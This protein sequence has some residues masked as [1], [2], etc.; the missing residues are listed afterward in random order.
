L[1]IDW[2]QVPNGGYTLDGTGNAI[3]SPYTPKIGEVV[4]RYGPGN[5]D[6]HH[7]L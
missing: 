4:D 6:I 2:S 1:G 3:K 7:Q 5:V